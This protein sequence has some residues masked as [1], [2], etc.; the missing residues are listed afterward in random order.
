MSATL[1]WRCRDVRETMH[2]LPD[3]MKLEVLHLPAAGSAAPTS[4]RPP[5]LF[6]HGSYH[7]AWCWRERFM[8]YFS[9]AGYDCY[10]FSI[11]GQGGSD[12]KTPAGEPLKVSG[13]LASLTDD[14]ADVVAALPSPPVV[15]AHSFGALLV[16]KYATQLGQRPPL[17]GLAVLCGTPPSGNKAIVGRVMKSSLGLAWQITW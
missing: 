17:A 15:V 1:H 2:T 3:G 16:E 12:R 8:P 4:Q 9:A 13:D 6:V 11:R 10:A 14:L 5:L 7:G